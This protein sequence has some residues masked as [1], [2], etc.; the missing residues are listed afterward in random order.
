MWLLFLPGALFFLFKSQHPLNLS[1]KTFSALY[2]AVP[3]ERHPRLYDKGLTSAIEQEVI[4]P[5]HTISRGP[6]TVGPPEA[7]L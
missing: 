2:G 7:N 5:R 4:C 3:R 6:L 1:V